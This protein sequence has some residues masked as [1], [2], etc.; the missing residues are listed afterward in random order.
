MMKKLP[1]KD[2]FNNYDSEITKDT[3]IIVEGKDERVF[4][5]ELFNKND[6]LK[7]KVIDYQI[8]ELGGVDNLRKAFKPLKLRTGFEKIKTLVVIIDADDN[9]DSALQKVR[10][11]LINHGFNCP[12]KI[13][14]FAEGKIRVGIF[15]MPGNLEG[16]MLEDLC[17][18]IVTKKFLPDKISEF[19]DSLINID[20]Y[21]KPKNLSKAKILIYLALN[22]DTVNSLG[23]GTRKGYF[24]LNSDKLNELVEF[25]NKL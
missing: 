8:E 17:L 6:I 12:S 18:A 7:E 16:R 21:S 23:I 2:S 1:L 9:K 20:G 15:I 4:L 5:D 25:L 13:G 22:P 19:I 11:I 24:N 3:L 14:E 10:N